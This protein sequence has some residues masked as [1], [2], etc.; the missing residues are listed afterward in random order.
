[1]H[2]HPPWLGIVIRCPPFLSKP[3]KQSKSSWI[4]PVDDPHPFNR[5]ITHSPPVFWLLPQDLSLAGDCSDP[6]REIWSHTC[7]GHT[8]RCGGRGLG[9]VT[10][11]GRSHK[12]REGV[13]AG[14]LPLLFF[15]PIAFLF[16]FRRPFPNL[17]L[18]IYL[19]CIYLSLLLAFCVYLSTI[20]LSICLC[21]VCL[22]ASTQALISLEAYGT[23]RHIN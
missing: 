12:D 6:Q 3:L 8:N 13:G 16:C 1:M 21:L 9:S 20:Y 19:F 17:V 4:P 7:C 15:S 22:S 10:W 2:R 11:T 23:D 5:S 18:S 14:I